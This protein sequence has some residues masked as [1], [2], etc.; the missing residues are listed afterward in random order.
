MISKTKT[1]MPT[2]MNN[3]LEINLENSTKKRV[4]ENKYKEILEIPQE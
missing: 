1:Q 2:C 4:E 3:I